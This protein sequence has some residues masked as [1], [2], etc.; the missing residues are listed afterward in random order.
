MNPVGAVDLISLLASLLALLLWVRGSRRALPRDARWLFLG[1]LG[2]TA[3]HSLS[4]VLEWLGGVGGTDIFEDYIE[5]LLPALWGSF[6]YAFLRQAIEGELRESEEKYRNVVERANDGITIIQD[7]TVKYANP[8]LAEMWGGSVEEVIG[9]SFLDYVHPDARDQVAE[10]YEQRMIGQEKLGRYEIALQ[11]RDGSPLFAEIN[12]ALTTLAGRP[13]DLVIVRDITARMQAEDEIRRLKEFN[14]NL[15]QSMAEGIAVEDEEGYFTFVNPAAAEMLGYAPEELVGQHVTIVIPPDQ[16]AIVRA[17][18]ARR[19]RGQAD[20]YEVEAMR[21][22][23]TRLSL[24]VSGNPQFEAGRFSGTVAVFTDITQLKEAE[25][26]QEVL[27]NIASAVHTTSDL[28]D[29]YHVIQRELGRIL[30]TRNFFIALHDPQDD[31]IA[32]PFLTDEK[33]EVHSFPAGQTLTAH[34]IQSDRPFLARRQ[35]LEELARTDK[36]KLVGTPSKVWLGVPLK[37]PGQ[38]IGALVMQ[39][40]DDENAFGQKELDILE[41][42]SGQIGLSIERKQAQESLQQYTER[43]RILREIDQAILAAE[44]PRAIA[45][46]AM[47]HI[48]QLIPSH[49]AGI[50]LFDFE[51]NRGTVLAVHVNGQTQIGPDTQL[52]LSALNIPEK[53]A[54]GQVSV[55]EDIQKLRKPTPVIQKLREEGVRSSVGLPL[56]VQDQLIGAFCLGADRPGA[57]DGEQI[58][59]AREVAD[60]LAIAIHQAQLREQV[61]RHTEELEQRVA[62]RTAELRQNEEKLRAQ[63]KGIPMPTYT[64]QKTGDDFVLVDFNDA[65]V[66][67]TQGKIADFLGVTVREMYEDQPEIWEEME[68]CFK[69]QTT[70]EREMLY[71][72]RTTGE[73]RYLAV[74]YAFVPPDLVLVHTDDITRQK[75]LDR[76]KDEFVSNVSHELRNPLTNLK[77]FLSLLQDSSAEKQA[78]YLD[79]LQRETARLT[80]II[81]D[82][83]EVSRLDQEA[84]IRMEPVDL[85]SLA[86]EV[87]TH[88]LPQARAKNI[89]LTFDAPSDLPAACANAGQIVQVLTNLL[90]NALAYTP[91][92]GHVSVSIAQGER[93]GRGGL[94]LTVADDGPG[95]SPEDRLHLFE[96]FYRGKVGRESASGTGLGLSICKKIVDLH[97]GQITVK[98]QEGR[99]SAFTVWLPMERA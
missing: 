5:I 74:K 22:D 14:E 91:K 16:R 93:N 38:V 63:Y 96:R 81:E 3:F 46:S 53:W 95:I 97:D 12:A 70:V 6:L 61:Q 47:R 52:L 25:E 27:H 94:R 54:R 98:S 36:A 15:V 85:E 13:A 10:R 7:G 80:Q 34:V 86:A 58:V 42:V 83:L 57:F 23:S 41:F 67:I 32:V 99:G 68:K 89:E 77:L 71:R 87:L 82:L 28:N 2:L 29:L 65:A 39:S 75:E 66:S 48:R 1:L 88:H 4:N 21:K 56:V 11:R 60:Q 51:S 19:A 73:S 31:T 9:T 43:L 92:G 35:E 17:A 40:Y 50:A 26:I 69:D 20:R 37:K 33:Q 90:G 18:N 84:A 78:V 44:S 76:L 79:T 8:R 62:E 59:I 49:R 64:W 55:I 30:D 72:Y 24:L 45:Q